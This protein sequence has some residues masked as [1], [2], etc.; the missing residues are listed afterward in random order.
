[1]KKISFLAVV[2]AITLVFSSCS[3]EE[4][5][6]PESENTN[7]LK[8]YKVKRDATGAYSID[9]NVSNNTKIDK[10]TDVNSNTSEYVLS[11]SNNQ[12]QKKL[13]QELLIDNNKLKV[14]FV[15]A[16]TDKRQLISII[17]DNISFQN[18]SDD[19]K[20]LADY[21]IQG[22]EDGTFDLAFNVN[23]K[24]DVSFVYNEEISTYEIHLEDGAGG[25][26]NFSRTL[27][28]EDGQKLKIDFVNHSSNSVAKSSEDIT[29][30]KPRI[31]IDDGE[32]S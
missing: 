14:G 13:S 11:S 23:D 10:L 7:L 27:E 25:D 17:D 30:R 4:S 21:S 32:D 15:D 22:N 26:S 12:T 18:K 20:R 9:F 16:N 1:M 8:T 24:V 5:L 31:I 29:K 2:A 28:S 3:S 19:T 6:L